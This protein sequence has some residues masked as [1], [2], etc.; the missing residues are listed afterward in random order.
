MPSIRTV[1]LR[2]DDPDVPEPTGVETFFSNLRKDY[3]ER[4]DKAELDSIISGYQQNRQDEN[5]LEDLFLNISKSN[6]GPTKRLQAMEEIKQGQSV[7]AARDKA[8][9]AKLSKNIQS[10]ADKTIL[11]QALIADGYPPQEAR[12][13][14]NSSPGVQN[15]LERNHI[16]EKAR[17]KR[18]PTSSSEVNA[19]SVPFETP[20]ASSV[21]EDVEV[22]TPEDENAWPMIAPPENMNDAERVKWGNENQKV[23]TKELKEVEAK[24]K[25]YQTNDIL[26]KSMT[27]SNDSG[28]LPS[29]LGKAI[30]VDPSTGDIRPTAQLLEQINPE[31]ELY[32]K[33]LKQ[34]LKGAKDFFGARVTDFDVRSFMAQLPGLLNSEQGRR[35]ILKQMELVNKLEQTHN[36]ELDKG[37]KHYGR[38]A[39]YIDISK[40]VDQRVSGKEEKLISQINNVAKGSDYLN[41]MSKNPAKFGDSVLMEKNGQFKAVK[42]QDVERAKASDWSVF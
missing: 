39:S 32:I 15:T 5:A 11:E 16:N 34:F 6:I 7:V 28:K 40:T 38:N 9:N 2:R 27:R 13:Y 41:K 20:G 42:K 31:T 29:G 22:L 19:A 10:E 3:V 23:N 21:S 26:I 1:N 25:A 24:K 33:N 12:L 18:K 37:L 8:L 14:V 30:I 35:V 36:N 17:G 4:R